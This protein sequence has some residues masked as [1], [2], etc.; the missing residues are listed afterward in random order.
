MESP[1]DSRVSKLT[2]NEG[3]S[4]MSFIAAGA[5]VTTNNGPARYLDKEITNNVQSQLTSHGGFKKP[6]NMEDLLSMTSGGVGSN[7]ATTVN[8]GTARWFDGKRNSLANNKL[9][10]TTGNKQVV[11]PR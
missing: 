4:K 10:V 11:S 9:L 5:K 1:K 3:R 2:T 8:T 7:R 6:T